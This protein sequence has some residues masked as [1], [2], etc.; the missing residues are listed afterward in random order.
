MYPIADTL[1]LVGAKALA[2]AETKALVN[3]PGP[4]FDR[5]L[6]SSDGRTGRLD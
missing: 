6:K 3:V 2:K 5:L 1:H 4:L